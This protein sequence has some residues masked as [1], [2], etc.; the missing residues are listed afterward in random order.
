VHI[1][2]EVKMED[3]VLNK[4]ELLTEQKN[5]TYMKCKSCEST[6]IMPV[7]VTDNNIMLI[8]RKCFDNEVINKKNYSE[9]SERLKLKL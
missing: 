9:I 4:F 7:Q 1:S 3:I 8:C 6:D 2:K 5:V